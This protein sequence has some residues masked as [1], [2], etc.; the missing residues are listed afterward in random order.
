VPTYVYG[1]SGAGAAGAGGPAE[2][3]DQ[4][5]AKNAIQ[6]AAKYRCDLM[7]KNVGAGVGQGA[8]IQANGP[9]TAG[10]L[11]KKDGNLTFKPDPQPTTS[12]N[13]NFSK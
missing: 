3:A 4:N 1:L 12:V 8:G 13:G 10:Q 2:A 11:T 5:A 7:A 6:K 9:L